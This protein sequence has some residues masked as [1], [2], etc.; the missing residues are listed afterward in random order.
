MVTGIFQTD[1][2]ILVFA[3]VIGEVK[4][5]ISKNEQ[6]PKHVFQTY[7]LGMK[8]LIVCVNK[9]NS[10]EPPKSQ[11]TYEEIVK[12]IA[13]YHKKTG[14]NLDTVAFMPTSSWNGD[15]ILEPIVNMPWFKG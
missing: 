6:T 2:A 15:I 12:E 3:A 10:T 1:C 13:T 14:Y 9:M 5:G 4:D 11:K 8:Q 7:T